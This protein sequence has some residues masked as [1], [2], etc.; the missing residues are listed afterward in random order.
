MIEKYLQNLLRLCKS[1]DSDFFV[2]GGPVRDYLLKRKCSDFDFSTRDASILAKRYSRDIKSP[3]VPLDTTPGRETFRVVIQKD[4]YFDFSELQG[5][6]IESDLNKRDFTLNAMAVPLKNFLKGTENF[7]DP[8]NGKDDIKNKIIRMLP[9]SPFLN[10]PLRMLRAFRFMSII[11]F[12]I[13]EDTFAKIKKLRSK[14]NQVAPERIFNELNLLLSSKKASPSILSMHNSGLLKCIFQNLYKNKEL[15]PSLRVL[16]HLEKLLSDPKRTGTKPITKIKKI[17]LSKPELIKLGSILYPLVKISPARTIEQQGKRSRKTKVG[18]LLTK[19]RASNAEIDF[20][21]A[22]ISCWHSASVSKLK[23]AGPYPDQFQI[24]RFIKQNEEGL[25]PGLFLHLANRPKL[26]TVKNWKTD[27][28][29]IPV[30]NILDFYFRTYL[31]AK[32]KKPLLDG[33]DIQQ[34]FKIK[35]NPFFTT[36][37]YKVEEARVIGMINTRSE[38]IHFAKEL[39]DE[40]QKGS[41]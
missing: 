26:P 4:I 37:L 2:V 32:A 13:E 27:A 40:N 17:L 23:F 5:G 20:I 41:D 35:P 14:I 25:I 3:L 24:C 15:L 28:V 39:I 22:L 7:I 30:R 33:N 19:L 31:P 6:S 8:Y 21:T 29:S 12:Q 18:K 9:D 34:K 10:D 38:A 36:I 1:H 11:G 16:D